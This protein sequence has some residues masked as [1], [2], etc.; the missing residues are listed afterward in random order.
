MAQLVPHLVAVTLP[1]ELTLHRPSQ[2]VDRVYF[3][4]EG[5]CSMVVTLE[6]GATIEVGR[7]GREGFV[8]MAAILGAG[9]SPYR[10]FMA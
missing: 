1:K 7:I 3:L 4:E 8:G 5:I 9:H 6:S 10:F 2:P